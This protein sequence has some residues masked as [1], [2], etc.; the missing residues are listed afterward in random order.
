M[1]CHYIWVYTVVAINTAHDDAWDS[2]NTFRMYSDAQNSAHIC[3]YMC[4]HV[5]LVALT[6]GGREGSSS[7]PPPPPP[8]FGKGGHSPLIHEVE[9]SGITLL[10]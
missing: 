7:H 9:H 1:L 4:M 2:I 6:K 5:I 3:T 10:Q 8:N